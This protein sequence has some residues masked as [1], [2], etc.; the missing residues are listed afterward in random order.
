L[1]ALFS[2]SFTQ[3]FSNHLIR[4]LHYEV[5]RALEQGHDIRIDRLWAACVVRLRNDVSIGA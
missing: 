4:R 3:L 5:M 1:S 2:L